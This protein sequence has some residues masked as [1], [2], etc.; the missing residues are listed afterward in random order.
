[1]KG[2]IE[3]PQIRQSAIVLS[4][5]APWRRHSRTVLELPALDQS[6][7]TYHLDARDRESASMTAIQKAQALSTPPSATSRSKS[8]T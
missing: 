4:R 5:H 7:L 8:R 2:S 1:M 3:C 6:R